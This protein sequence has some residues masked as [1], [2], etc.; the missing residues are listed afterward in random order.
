MVDLY[1]YIYK[2]KIKKI[3]IKGEN[4]YHF[5][6]LPVYYYKE[7][8]LNVIFKKPDKQQKKFW[9]FVDNLSAKNKIDIQK[10]NG[11]TISIDNFNCRLKYLKYPLFSLKFN[12]G[13]WQKNSRIW[14]YFIVK[15]HKSVIKNA[16][17]KKN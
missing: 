17:R 9:Y 5:V 10:M 4:P 3:Y 8:D 14:D 11:K 12:I 13:N 1:H 15:T 16:S 7:K 2:N 6:G